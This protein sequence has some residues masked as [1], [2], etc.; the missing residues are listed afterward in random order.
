MH[1]DSKRFLI[2]HITSYSRD[3]AFML[4]LLKACLWCSVPQHQTNCDASG[5]EGINEC[6]LDITVV[7]YKEVK[8]PRALGQLAVFDNFAPGGTYVELNGTT[9]TRCF[10]VLIHTKQNIH[11]FHNQINPVYG[12][13]IHLKS[14]KF[15]SQ[16]RVNNKATLSNAKPLYGVH[17]RAPGTVVGYGVNLPKSLSDIFFVVKTYEFSAC[18]NTINPPAG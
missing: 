13:L 2:Q 9:N 15:V 3:E 10:V 7:C 5:P 8:L 4:I 17:A 1:F 16:L 14:P 6:D 11:L 12:K 18:F